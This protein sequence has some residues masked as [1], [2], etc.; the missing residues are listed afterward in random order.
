M[1]R[2]GF[3]LEPVITKYSLY[4]YKY[5]KI[6]GKVRAT[7]YK[8]SNF[9]SVILDLQ[10]NQPNAEDILSTIECFTS[11]GG[12]PYNFKI[13]YVAVKENSEQYNWYKK[14]GYVLC[15]TYND[16][17]KLLYKELVPPLKLCNSLCPEYCTMK[18]KTNKIK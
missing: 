8:Y 6:N 9:G 4:K 7:F 11:I 2:N 10:I 5:I 15:E 1:I 14:H 12:Y 13:V 3:E 16:N 18:P 17:L